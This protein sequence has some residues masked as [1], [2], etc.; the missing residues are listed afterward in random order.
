MGSSSILPK[1]VCFAGPFLAPWLSL[2][3][4]M[5]RCAA[6]RRPAGVMSSRTDDDCFIC[7]A[8]DSL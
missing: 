2:R 7:D 6:C 3:P 8:S 5:M 4:C 1:P